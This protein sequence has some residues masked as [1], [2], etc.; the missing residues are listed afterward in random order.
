MKT[1]FQITL[2]V[3][4]VTCFVPPESAKTK[5]KSKPTTCSQGTP[6]RGCPACG[7]AKDAKHITLD[8]QKNRGIK[9]TNPQTLTVADIR[10]SSQQQREVLTQ[11]A[12]F[13]NRLRGRC[14]SRRDAGEL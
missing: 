10:E 6:Y 11:Q 13:G 8:V 7:T 12:G 2:L 14:G 4:A 5:P 9:V 3:A 1:L